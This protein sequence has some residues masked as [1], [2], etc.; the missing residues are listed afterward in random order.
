MPYPSSSITQDTLPHI[1]IQLF[2]KSPY[3]HTLH[4]IFHDIPHIFFKFLFSNLICPTF[5]LFQS[6]KALV[7]LKVHIIEG[8]R[9]FINSTVPPFLHQ[10]TVQYVPNL[11]PFPKIDF[12]HRGRVALNHLVPY[13]WYGFMGSLSIIAICCINEKSINFD[14]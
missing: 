14:K 13:L 11:K 6:H 2:L 9:P 10:R 4:Y 7:S 8:L 3:F 1:N 12:H 5:Y